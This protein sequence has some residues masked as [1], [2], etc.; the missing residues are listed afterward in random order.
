MA[1]RGTSRTLSVVYDPA[2]QDFSRIASKTFSFESGMEGW[3]TMS[4]TFVRSTDNG[5]GAQLSGTYLASSALTSGMCDQVRSP[6]VKLTGS[7][8]LTVYNQ[9]VTEPMSDTWYDR[10]NVGIFD[11]AAA[12]RTTVVPS[13]GRPYLASGPN[14]VCAT[15][16]QP[17]WAGAGPGWLPSTWSAADLGAASLAGR[18]VQLDVAYGTDP[19]ASATGLWIDEVTLTDFDLQGAD[20]QPDACAFC[21]P[22]IDDA[23]PG[24]EYTGGWVQ[25]NDNTATAGRYRKRCGNNPKGAVA[26]V[27]FEGASITYLYG[28]SA[29]GGSADLYLDGVKVTTLSYAGSGNPTFGRSITFA[30]L[31]PGGH[32][33]EVRHVSGTVFVDGF[34]FN[35]ASGGGADRSAPA[36][37]NQ[38]SDKTATSA[39]GAV[40]NVPVEVKPGD[41]AVSVLVEGLPSAVTVQLLGPLGQLVASG[42]ARV[43]GLAASG[44]D[45]TAPL[46]PGN[47]TVRIPNPLLPGQTAT[48]SVVRTIPAPQ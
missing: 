45:T 14:G 48:V 27:V 41:L 35:C 9:F 26:K 17:G 18:K 43:P 2:E 29:A 11:V 21:T 24:V 4:G 1:A 46:S 28:V 33:F 15:G 40:I 31:A 10:G 37:A 13:G 25:K 38:Q 30:N 8:T 3:T 16:G 5:G 42:G 34:K 12:T 6:V 44:L 19:T 36:V 47:Y 20:A 7:S 32:T 39:D 22:E 23:D